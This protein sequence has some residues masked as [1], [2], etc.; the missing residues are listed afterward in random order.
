VTNLDPHPIYTALEHELRAGELDTVRDEQCSVC[1]APV[2][3]DQP[4]SS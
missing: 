4:S 3:P 1:D 2:D